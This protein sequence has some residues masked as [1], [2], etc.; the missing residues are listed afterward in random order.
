MLFVFPLG[1]KRTIFIISDKCKI[2]GLPVT[3]GGQSGIKQ[4]IPFAAFSGPDS[5][6]H[7]AIHNPLKKTNKWLHDVPT[8]TFDYFYSIPDLGFFPPC[9]YPHFVHYKDTAVMCNHCSSDILV[10]L[11]VGRRGR[12]LMTN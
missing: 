4:I 2:R 11:A 6:S 12:P 5:D 3:V 10:A 7:L 9:F 1:L 8:K